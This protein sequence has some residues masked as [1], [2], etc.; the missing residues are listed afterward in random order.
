MEREEKN[1][2]FVGF[3]SGLSLNMEGEVGSPHP[4]SAQEPPWDPGVGGPLWEAEG[5]QEGDRAML[6]CLAS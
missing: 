1:L 4:L 6:H 5:L 2:G 3:S